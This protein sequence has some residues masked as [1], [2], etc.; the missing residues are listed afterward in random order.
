MESFQRV[1]NWFISEFV[2]KKILLLFWPFFRRT[3]FHHDHVVFESGID[4]FPG[5]DGEAGL[6]GTTG[7]IGIPGRSGN[8]GLPG[9]QILF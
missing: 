6:K 4:G 5:I 9:I 2:V 7:D 8:R 1:N 3:F